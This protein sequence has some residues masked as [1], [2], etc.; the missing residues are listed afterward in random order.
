MNTGELAEIWRVSVV[1]IAF[2]GLFALLDWWQ[3]DK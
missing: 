1:M 3:S 2:A